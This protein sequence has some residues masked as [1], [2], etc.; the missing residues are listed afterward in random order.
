MM[1]Q[2][3]KLLC[4]VLCAA[5]I[6]AA[7]MPASLALRN[8]NGS[9]AAD[10]S[11]EVH[12]AAFKEL[13]KSFKNFDICKKDCKTAVMKADF[14]DVL[15]AVRTPVR[16]TDGLD[17]VL[18]SG[19]INTAEQI[20]N[21]EPISKSTFY[22]S[23]PRATMTRVS[24]AISSIAGKTISISATANAN[25]IMDKMGLLTISVQRYF[26]GRWL[27]VNTVTEVYSYGVTRFTYVASR[28]DYSSGAYYRVTATFSA[29]KYG[30]VY[31]VSKATD[32]IR[33]K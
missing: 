8:P 7:F 31:N 9:S 22:T 23:S 11:A 1:K 2:N 15:A 16:I 4:S 14:A 24:L 6:F 28:A 21:V 5:F 32:A 27:T 25:G 12:T 29:E 18:L 19:K 3:L 10:V 13:P 17:C 33:C 20:W 30:M 26:K